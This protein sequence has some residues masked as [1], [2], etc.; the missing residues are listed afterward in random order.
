MFSVEAEYGRI[1]QKYAAL[2]VSGRVMWLATADA[3]MAFSIHPYL[4]LTPRFRIPCPGAWPT[5]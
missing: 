3:G 4:R 5:A 2:G 1:L